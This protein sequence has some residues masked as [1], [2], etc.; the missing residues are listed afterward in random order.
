MPDGRSEIRWSPRVPKWKVRRLYESDAQGML[1][2]ELL[3]DVGIT[4]LLRC[5]DILAIHEAR[6]QGRVQCPRCARQQRETMIQRL[7]RSQQED[8]RDEVLTCPACGLQITW[9][10]YNLSFKRKQLHSGGAVTA[11]ERYI[12]A[13]PAAP[14]PQ[15]KM[16]AVDWLIYEFHY[17]LRAQPD[18]PIRP[19]GTN[20]IEGKVADVVRFL[21]ELNYGDRPPPEMRENLAA[22]RAHRADLLGWPGARGRS[23]SRL[24]ALRGWLARVS[25]REW[26]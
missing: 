10:E 4:L 21:D 9:G 2:V 18:L 11:F 15:A 1:D 13:Y 12:R 14:T 23:R 22:W 19:V 17:S 8:V 5:R 3:D 20:L 24:A 16:L 7:P 6:V 25:V 26:R